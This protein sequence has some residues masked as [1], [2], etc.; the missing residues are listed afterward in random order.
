MNINNLEVGDTVNYKPTGW[1]D[2]LGQL[3]RFGG[4]FAHTAIISKLNINKNRIYII[5]A[6]LK[7]GVVEKVLN[8][9]W[10]KHIE[11]RRINGG[12]SPED[13]R[14]IIDFMRSKIG[15]KYGLRD[16]PDVI[17]S[18]F[19]GGRNRK[20]NLNDSNRFFCSELV[21]TGYA[22]INRVIIKN[23][24][25]SRTIPSDFGSKNSNTTIVKV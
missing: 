13:K 24:H 6:H 3:F 16:F 17:Y 10:Y 19:F 21:A 22:E 18:L 15:K 25:Y 23:V 20:S 4:K 2:I 7:T 11:I 1:L 5:E 8:T 14:D 9:K 12:L